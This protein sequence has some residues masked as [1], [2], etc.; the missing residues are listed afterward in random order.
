V[1]EALEYSLHGIIESETLR[2][3]TSGEVC[4]MHPEP[5]VAG[6]I[7]F[8]FIPGEGVVYLVQRLYLDLHGAPDG[9]WSAPA[10]EHDNIAADL[11]QL[12]T[13]QLNVA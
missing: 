11:C 5:A 7:T 3:R 9:G 2:R 1:R 12:L 10:I 13:A 8:P 4:T 6:A